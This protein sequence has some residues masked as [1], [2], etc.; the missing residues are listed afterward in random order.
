MSRSTVVLKV[1]LHRKFIFPPLHWSHFTLWSAA[2]PG[3]GWWN[4]WANTHCMEKQPQSRAW[5]PRLWPH[6][7]QN[8]RVNQKPDIYT[9]I[10]PVII[11]SFVTRVKFKALVELRRRPSSIWARENKH[12]CNESGFRPNSFIFMKENGKKPELFA[13][14]W[15]REWWEFTWMQICQGGKQKN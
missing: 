6:Q 8:L 3:R 14:T 7:P 12:G 15:Q 10:S 5:L 9:I 2:F 13:A 1:I 11:F 4:F